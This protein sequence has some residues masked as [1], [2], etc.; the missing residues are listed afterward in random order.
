MLI[1]YDICF[2][3]MVSAWK[4][5]YALVDRANDVGDGI[6]LIHQHFDMVL[7]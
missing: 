7:K 1:K 6:D 2:V 5:A 4:L 3:G